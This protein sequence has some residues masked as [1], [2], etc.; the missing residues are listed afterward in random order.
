MEATF[1]KLT[2]YEYIWT[3]IEPKGPQGSGAVVYTAKKPFGP[4]TALDNI[5]RHGPYRPGQLSF[6]IVPGQQTYVANLNGTYVWMA[7][8]WNSYINPKTKRN[9]KS[10]DYQAWLP[11]TFRDDGSIK[12]LVWEDSWTAPSE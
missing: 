4:Y 2:C 12:R 10:F 1:K 11:L 5:N 8:L 9:V 6:I 3:P 7:D